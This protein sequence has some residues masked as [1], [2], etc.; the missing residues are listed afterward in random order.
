MAR[1]KRRTTNVY[2][3]K[4][5]QINISARRPINRRR[6]YDNVRPL[7]SRPLR[8]TSR[9][10]DTLARDVSKS[11]NVTSKKYHGRTLRP[12]V[13]NYQTDGFKDALIQKQRRICRSR[14]QRR[15]I[16]FARGRS[17]GGNRRPKWNIDSYIT[18]VR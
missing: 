15:E 7:L 12:N 18:C 3:R 4:T 5:Q 10:V 11:R 9:V 1:R 17:G 8:P 14:K 2:N 16:M 6:F 13:R